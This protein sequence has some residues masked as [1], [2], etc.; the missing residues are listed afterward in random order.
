MR[1][2]GIGLLGAVATVAVL[3][4]RRTTSAAAENEL[5][6][7]LVLPD[8][9]SD[10]PPFLSPP[11]YPVRGVLFKLGDAAECQSTGKSVVRGEGGELRV[12]S[13]TVRPLSRGTIDPQRWYRLTFQAEGPAD[14]KIQVIFREP[15]KQSFRT[16]EA[17][18]GKDARAESGLD[19]Q[20]PVFA[21]LAEIRLDP[22]SGELVVNE[23]S[24]SMIPPK[25]R[26]EPVQSFRGSFVPPGYGLVFN[27]EFN[28]KTLDR[29]AW[30][31][32]YIY[33]GET[34]DHLVRENQRYTDGASH[35]VSGGQLHLVARKKPLSQPSGI[36]Y[37]SGMIRSDFT[38]RYGFIEARVKMPG[39]LGVWPAFWLNSDVSASGRLE[40]PPEIDMFELVNNGKDDTVDRLHI[41]ASNAPAFPNRVL[42]MAPEFIERHRS[43]KAPFRF[44]QG[45]HTI[46][47]EWTPTT[48]TTYVDGKPAV[49]TT[50]RW[51]Y[52]DATDA[53]PAHILLNLAIGG[54]WAGRYGIDDKAFP[55][56]LDVDWVRVYQKVSEPPVPPASP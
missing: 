16:F 49:S 19:F 55:Q 15:R 18:C 2:L 3:F 13:K 28:G 36:N 53:G 40:H 31:T 14:A 56:S 44:D 34:L 23:L 1:I 9:A 6:R 41:A 45:F 5:Q 30:F 8:R 29:S 25:T 21:D 38:Y 51:I 24:L 35:V 47:S 39:G 20:A 32:R 26:T 37:E 52:E 11:G 50:F 7:P 4:Y 42:Y 54:D 22:G 48:L 43:Y 10:P 27:D 17:R 33:G 46:G 12:L